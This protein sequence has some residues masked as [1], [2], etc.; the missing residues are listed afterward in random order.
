MLKVEKLYS[1]LWR[2]AQRFQSIRKCVKSWE[3]KR[4]NVL[5][6]WKVLECYRKCIERMER[7]NTVEK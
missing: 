4:E 1:N 7:V 6:D 3:R 5:K 2:F